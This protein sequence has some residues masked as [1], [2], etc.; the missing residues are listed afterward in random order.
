MKVFCKQERRLDQ[1]CT[2]LSGNRRAEKFYGIRECW[3]VMY[4]EISSGL[5]NVNKFLSLIQIF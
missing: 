5:S 2:Q 3:P 1:G 4:S